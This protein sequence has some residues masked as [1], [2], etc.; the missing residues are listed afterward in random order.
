MKVDRDKAS[1]VGLNTGMIAIAIR[2][3]IYGADAGEL[4][5]MDENFDIKVRYA[6]EFRDKISELD[7]LMLTT[8]TG[9]TI[10][11]STVATLEEGSGPLEIRHE[12]QQ[13][14]VKVYADAN[15]I[16]LGEAV[17]KVRAEISKLDIP[18]DVVV[19]MGGKADAKD[20]SFG[21]LYLLFALG[22]AMV[23]M[24][25]ASQFGSLKDP[26][27]IM[28]SVP[29]SIIGVVMAFLIS[30]ESLSV[31]TFIGVIMLIGIVVNNGIV[32]VDY[33]NLLR[34]RG[35]NLKEAILMAGNSRLRPVMM[36][37]LTTILGMVPLANSSGMGS[38]MWKPL[39]ITVIGGLLVSTLIT[40]VF[41]PVIYMTFHRKDMN[42]EGGGK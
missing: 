25:M 19:E 16:S 9:V 12:S 24:V 14:V 39:G 36:T 26:L 5:D 31:V 6:P 37:A 23:Y 7:N 32:L 4:K 3:S 29:L 30:G 22:L 27:I 11:L 15:G 33:I 20:E 2:Q 17:S 13:R 42:V 21:S 34:A 28:F 1:A 41:V 38:E 40:L 18:A 35:H 8:L 10:P